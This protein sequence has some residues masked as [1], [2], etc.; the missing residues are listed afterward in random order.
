M[1]N[2]SVNRPWAAL[3]VT[4]GL[5]L[6]AVVVFQGVVTAAP[7]A[8]AQGVERTPVD[9]GVWVSFGTPGSRL[10]MSIEDLDSSETQRSLTEGALVRSVALGSPAADAGL[11]DG[12]IVVEFDAERVRSARQLSRLVQET[13]V[14]REV[15]LLVVRDSER[16]VLNVTPEEGADSLTAIQDWMPD[17]GRWK[18]RLEQVLPGTRQQR[19]RQ[20]LGV[21]VTD[22]GPQLAEYFGVDRGVLVTMVAS[23]SV[24]AEAGLQAGDVL[25]AIDGKPIDDVGALHR[26]MAAIAPPATVQLEASRDGDTITL[27]ARFER[28]PEPQRR[29]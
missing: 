4:G 6:T 20:R 26:M 17:L 11:E 24:A 28:T 14:G 10:G 3:I 21:E 1:R 23:G 7:P 16:L 5:I 15:P 27:S 22:V 9:R 29:V 18:Q 25:T 19:G 8:A 2:Q 12:D 13:P